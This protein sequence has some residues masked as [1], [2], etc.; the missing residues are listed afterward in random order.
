MTLRE[1]LENA[2]LLTK[3]DA[4]MTFTELYMIPTDRMSAT[5]D[6]QE[7]DFV[8]CYI[9]DGTRKFVRFKEGSDVLYS[10]SEKKPIPMFQ[11][12]ACEGILRLFNYG[13]GFKVVHV[14]LTFMI[15]QA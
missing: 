15:E 10:F 4:D 11:I 2:P 6:H 14:N 5:S 3:E 7:I 1:R 12:D 8:A 9:E 13:N